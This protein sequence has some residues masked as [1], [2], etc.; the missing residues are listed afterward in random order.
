[1]VPACRISP[2]I[3]PN[4]VGDPPVCKQY[5]EL[6]PPTSSAIA[7]FVQSAR[8]STTRN[9]VSDERI[10]CLLL[11][12]LETGY[13][14]CPAVALDILNDGRCCRVNGNAVGG[15]NDKIIKGNDHD[16]N[17]IF[18]VLYQIIMENSHTC[19]QYLSAT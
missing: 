18:V 15:I 10:P 9:L 13:D 17:V 5:S 16:E 14:P 8:C 1:M 6:P 2:P 19:L 11:P 3:P 4:T 7:G 12:L